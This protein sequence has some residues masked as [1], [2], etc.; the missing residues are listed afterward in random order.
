MKL[1]ALRSLNQLADQEPM[2]VVDTREQEPL[3]F[4]SLQAVRGTLLSGD[5]SVAGQEELF[6]VK[7]KSIPDLASC[8]MGSNRDALNTNC[9]GCEDTALNGS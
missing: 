4:K 1:P 8:C 7:R 6:S 9:T 2:I 5:Y 3:V